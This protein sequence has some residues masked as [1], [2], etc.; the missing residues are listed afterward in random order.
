MPRGIK[1]SGKSRKP[2]LQPGPLRRRGR[3]PKEVVQPVESPAT[4]G[5]LTALPATE[6]PI[7]PLPADE[8][9]ATGETL[10]EPTVIEPVPDEGAS[11]PAPDFPVQT[12]ELVAAEAELGR[13]YAHVRIKPGSL[14]LGAAD[15]FGN[16][17]I[18]TIVCST[19]NVNERV[20]ATSDLFHVSM[21]LQCSKAA[22][23]AARKVKKQAKPD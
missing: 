10:T 15:G 16:K 18:V 4:E 13:K 5:Q 7:R 8:S 17:R 23:K 14:R 21:C 12:P 20:V 9:A 1:G 2:A 22:K 11:L 6:E 3:K 19:C